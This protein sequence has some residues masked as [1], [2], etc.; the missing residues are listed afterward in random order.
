MFSN[1]DL[2]IYIRKC[3]RWPNFD[4]FSWDMLPCSINEKR[5]E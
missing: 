2:E 5:I 3:E 1:F 4:D